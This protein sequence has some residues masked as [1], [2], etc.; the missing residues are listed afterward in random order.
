V[1]KVCCAPVE[2]LKRL[3]TVALALALALAGPVTTGAQEDAAGSSPQATDRATAESQLNEL[4]NR[5]DRLKSELEAS[6]GEH[7][8]EQDRLRA[9]DLQIQAASLE[10]RSLGEQMAAQRR[11]LETLERQRADYLASL[12]ARTAELARQL[13]SLYRTSRQSRVKLVLNQDDPLLLGRLLAYFDYVNRAQLDQIDL[14]R[15]ALTALAGM[16]QSIDRELGRLAGLETAQRELLENLGRQRD[17]RQA[18]L[19]EIADRIGGGESR[20]AELERDR[21][22]LEALLERL[23][24]VLADIPADLGRQHDVQQ[25]RGRLPMPVSGPVRHAFGQNRAG[26][27]AWQGWLIGAEAGVEVTA[28]AYGRIAF[29]DWLRGYGLLV[30]I[31]HGQGFM[32]LYG[33]NESLLQEAGAWVEAGEVISVVG[34][35]PGSD[36][37][38]YFELRKDGKAIDPAQWLTR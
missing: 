15:E 37:G 10:L 25:Q 38:L 4:R 8:R 2:N 21:R 33:H 34:A 5:I 19:A 12:D 14:L 31:D 27:L 16:Q 29:A 13:R 6:R 9:L 28:V 26:G 30:I 24:D 22:D 36:Q 7:R 11:E 18:L 32:S 17:A 1:T 23:S 35:N 3:L 20:L